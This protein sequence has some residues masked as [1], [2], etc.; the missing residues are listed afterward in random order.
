MKTRYIPKSRLGL[1]DRAI[2]FT[3]GIFDA[4]ISATLQSDVSVFDNFKYK[5]LHILQNILMRLPAY[6]LHFSLLHSN[7]SNNVPCISES[8]TTKNNYLGSTIIKLFRS[9]TFIYVNHP[10]DVDEKTIYS[11]ERYFGRPVIIVSDQHIG[12]DYD[13][14]DFLENSLC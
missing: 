1:F 3:P 10:W 12:L 14:F 11:L 4:E 5:S 13:E 9:K 7:C 6:N 8:T 2:N